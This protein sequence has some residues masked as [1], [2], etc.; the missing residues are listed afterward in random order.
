MTARARVLMFQGTGSDVGKSVIVAGLCRVFARRGLAVRPFKSQNMSNNAAITPDGGEIGRAQAFQALACGVAPS[1]DMNP[2]LLKPESDERAQIV[3][4]GKVLRH[5]EARAYQ[6]LKTTLLPLVLESFE[7]LKAQAELVLVEG[8]GS[9]AEMNLRSGDIANMGFAEAADI[10][11]VLVGDID[12]GGVIAAMVGTWELL[13]IA[14]RRRIR[15]TVINKFRGDVG[16]FDGGRKIIADRTGWADC[17]VVPFFRDLRLLPSEDG[18]DLSYY[19]RKSAAV[20]R[21]AVP[22]FPRISNFDDLDPLREEPDVE[23]SMIEPGRALPGD[24]DLVILPG[25]KSTIADLRSFREMGWDV[26][27]KGH[28]RR[29]GYV[30]GICGG[31]QMLGRTI[32][33]REGIEGAAERVDGL[34]L[35]DIETRLTAKKVLLPVSGV[36]ITTGERIRGFEMHVGRTEGPD[37]ERPWLRLDGRADGA[38]SRDGRVRGCYVHGLFAADEFRA[39]FLSSLRMRESSGFGYE[40]RVT[41]SL[42]AWANHLEEHLDIE[43]MIGFARLGA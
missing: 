4:R 26:D 37:C 28:L 22:I 38:I 13:P 27:L 31:Y 39:A 24:A 19:R 20:V 23:V 25:S 6:A 36:D 11:V 16:L 3:L 42:D 8:A 30:V 29:G 5:V 17:G 14:E 9:P 33:D 12:R 2:V 18:I 34:G 21:I 32:E 7:R 15:G 41:A 1:V 10:P 40:S 35:L 43:R